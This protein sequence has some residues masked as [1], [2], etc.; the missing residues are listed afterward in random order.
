MSD[1]ARATAARQTVA[2][3]PTSEIAVRRRTVSPRTTPPGSKA[4]NLTDREAVPSLR[5]DFVSIPGGSPASGLDTGRRKFSVSENSQAGSTTGTTAHAISGTGSGTVATTY[6]PEAKDKSTK[7]VF[8]QVMRELLDGV[9]TLP[10]KIVPSFAYQD[11]DTTGDFYHVDYVS[12]ENDP[13]YNGDDAGDFGVQG[14]AVSTPPVPASTSDTPNLSDA[15]MPAGA[16]TVVWDF[17][18]AAFSAAGDDQ[19]TYYG[20]VDWAYTKPKGIAGATAV[21]A[22]SSSD[23]G[24]KFESAV[25]LFNSNHGFK[26]PTKGSSGGSPA[27]PLLGAGIGAGAGA[28]LGLAVGGPLG[29]LVGG[30]IGGLAGLGIGAAAGGKRSLDPTGTRG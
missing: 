10:S 3:E 6:T 18:T 17:R 19:G 1:H 24:T 9:P 25:S 30:I 27:G 12:G 26:M 22:T 5:G 8:I 14:N 13:Y 29:A 4:T 20:Y 28:L 15:G 23:P 11:A 2:A 16:S 21:G 7:I